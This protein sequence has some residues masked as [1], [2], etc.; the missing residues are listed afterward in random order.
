MQRIAM[1]KVANVMIK[2]KMPAH[3]N[4]AEPRTLFPHVK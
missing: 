4:R 3:R 2:D 1:T